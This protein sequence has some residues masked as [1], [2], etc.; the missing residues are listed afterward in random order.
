MNMGMLMVYLQDGGLSQAKAFSWAIFLAE[1]TMVYGR[2]NE[3]VFM[4]VINFNIILDQPWPWSITPKRSSHAKSCNVGKE[5]HQ[6]SPSHHHK[7]IGGMLT[8]PRKMGGKHNILPTLIRKVRLYWDHSWY[9]LLPS[10]SV[11]VR[12]QL[13]PWLLASGYF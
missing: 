13:W 4:G 7:C 12:L 9:F 2:Y 11:E 6:P 3:L 10:S 1:K 8:I 5:F